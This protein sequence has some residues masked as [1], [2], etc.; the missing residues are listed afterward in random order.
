MALL[1][2]VLGAGPASAHAALVSSDPEDGSSMAAAPKTISLTFNENVAT[3]AYVAVTAPDGS[4]V[5]VKGVEAVDRTV[6]ADVADVGQR[7]R[8]SASYRVVSS[9]GHPISGTFTYEVTQGRIVAQVDTPKKSQSFLHRHKSHFIWGSLAAA[10][11]IALLLSP[12][13]RRNDPESA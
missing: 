1:A 5:R 7:G 2:L 12:L 8:F 11:A 9:D 13:R 3:P 10:A 6:T 4:T